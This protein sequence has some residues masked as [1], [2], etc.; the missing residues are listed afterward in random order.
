ML[1]APFLTCLGLGIKGSLMVLVTVE[2]LV[3]ICSFSS[4]QGLIIVS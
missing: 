3:E 1:F 2:I 4:S